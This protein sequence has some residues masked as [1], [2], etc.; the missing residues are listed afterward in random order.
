ME[1]SHHVIRG[2]LQGRE[3]L[4]ILARIMR[5]TTMVLFERIGLQPGMACLD[6]GCGGGDVT[7]ELAHKVEPSGHVIGIDIDQAKIEMAR[8]EATE[9]KLSGVEFRVS[10]IGKSDKRA[11]FDAVYT[12]FV[13]THLSDPASELAWMIGQLRPGGVVIVEDID[14]S[15][16]FCHSDIPSF[17]RYIELYSQVVQ[18]TGADPHI[19]KRLPELLLD[20][21]LKKVQMHV[22]QPAGIE[23]EVKLMAPITME[24]VVD[25]VLAHGLASRQEINRIVDDLYAVADDHRTVMSLP[26]V[27]QAW[28]YRET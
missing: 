23:G 26:R 9:L 20:T 27:V 25:S 12:R 8:R 10:E 14:F 22:A 17:R 2:G 7:V 28:G 13:L 24:N 1:H 19:G 15:G 18:R 16:H 6:V 3:R 5:P 11:A 21:G 4:R